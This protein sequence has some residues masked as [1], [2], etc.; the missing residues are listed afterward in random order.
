[1]PHDSTLRRQDACSSGL[2]SLDGCHLCDGTARK[3]QITNGHE[4]VGTTWHRAGTPNVTTVFQSRR[5]QSAK[6]QSSEFRK[7]VSTPDQRG[8]CLHGLFLGKTPRPQERGSL[9]TVTRRRTIGAGC[10]GRLRGNSGVPVTILHGF[11]Q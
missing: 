3:T 4:A 1:M 9:R 5:I 8:Q 6:P 11:E 7:G 10:P 2:G